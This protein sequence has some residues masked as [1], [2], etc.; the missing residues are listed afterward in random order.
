MKK[1]K[2]FLQGLL[3][4]FVLTS[5]LCASCSNNDD[6]PA[7]PVY[8]YLIQADKATSTPVSAIVLKL[9]MN[10]QP[11]YQVYSTL[12]KVGVNLFRVSYRTPYQGN[13]LKASGVFIVPEAP[14]PNM[15]TVVYTHGTIYRDEAPSINLSQAGFQ[16]STEL[17]LCTVFASAFNCVVLM[18]DYIGY[19][20]SE[21]IVHPYAHAESL[22]QASLDFVRA[23]QEY[24]GDSFNKRL[25]IAGYSEGGYAAVALQKKIQET[26]HTGL[27]VDKTIAGSG[28]YD[29]VASA[30]KILSTNEETNL[31]FISSYLWV[32]QM[33]KNN[34]GYSKGYDAIFSPE[35][36][37]LLKAGGYDLAY[38]APEKLSI[39]TNPTQLF[40]DG[41]RNG[42][43]GGTDTELLKMLADNS[44]TEFAPADSLLFVSGGADTWVDPVNTRSACGKMYAKGC[45]VWM[46]EVPGGDHYTTLPVFLAVLLDRMGMY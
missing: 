28:P 16:K 12:P 13:E 42:V 1:N 25:L 37:T 15:P 45:K 39:H 33:Y 26:S 7:P 6:A 9:A 24:A 35:D 20:D 29:Q 21:S 46:Y 36:H 43:T 17:F 2:L 3:I 40:A 14:N 44:L 18:P 32:F 23:Y 27:T 30:L 19:G 8:D 22:G 5:V 41:F 38:F 11:D 34:F 4:A 10:A 31:H